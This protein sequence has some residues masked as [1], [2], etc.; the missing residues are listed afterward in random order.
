MRE[1]GVEVDCRLESSIDWSARQDE[2]EI[3]VS[4]RRSD[5]RELLPAPQAE[6]ALLGRDLDVRSE[7]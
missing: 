6:I 5:H 3:D 7:P 2:P 4:S 1:E